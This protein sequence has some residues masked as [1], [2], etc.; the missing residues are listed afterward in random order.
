M[1]FS[2]VVV[3]GVVTLSNSEPASG[4]S[5]VF[6]LNT[7]MSDRAQI[8]VPQQ[9]AARCASNG[10][11]SITL[12]ANDDPTTTP[13]GTYYNVEGV[14][15]TETLFSFA[16][17]VPSAD[18]GSG[19]NLFSLAQLVNPEALISIPLIFGFPAAQSVWTATH[20]LERLPAAVS[21]YDTTG[22][23]RPLA[24]VENSITQT[25]VTFAAPLAG[26]LLI[27]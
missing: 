26:T 22:E 24:Q 5:V 25:V 21:V 11:F 4:A 23:L 27:S 12:N 7:P 20:D 15:E 8:V 2:Q 17:S 18:A 9:L 3:S 6:T 19:V 13:A 10:A 14:Y 1:S 16:V